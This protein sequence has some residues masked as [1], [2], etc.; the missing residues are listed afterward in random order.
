MKKKNESIA[1]Q[2]LL[3]GTMVFIVSTT[4]FYMLFSFVR[5]DLYVGAWSEETR[6]GF[7]FLVGVSTVVSIFGYWMQKDFERIE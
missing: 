4:F 1:K 2:A 6:V 7:A 5:W 3:F